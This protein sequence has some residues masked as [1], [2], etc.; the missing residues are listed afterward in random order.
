[1]AAS[2]TVYAN[3]A[4]DGLG[5][6]KVVFIN[7]KT[8]AELLRTFDSEYFCREFVRKLKHSKT[9]TLLSYPLYM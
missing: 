3:Q 5:F 6:Y 9:C 4:D 7:N 8:K 1:M 2:R